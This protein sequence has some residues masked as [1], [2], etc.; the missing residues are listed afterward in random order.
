M[1]LPTSPFNAA[2]SIAAGKSVIQLKLT[3]SLTGVTGVATTDLLTKTAHGLTAGRQLLYVSGTGF[4]GLTAGNIYYVLYVDAN[5]FKLSATNGGAVFDFT[6]DG[7]AGVF[8]PV[9]VFEAMSLT[10]KIEQTLGDILVPDAAGVLRKARTWL[11]S[12]VEHFPFDTFEVKRLMDVFGGAMAGRAIGT[13]TL[14]IPDPDD[15][16][17]MIALKSEVDFACTVT[18]SGDG[19]YGN[20]DASKTSIDIESNKAGMVIWTLDSAP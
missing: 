9:H 17:G 18:R 16:S 10:S 11:K 20:S 2:K 1:S 4:T 3:P 14:W 13:A 19:S 12:Q 6:V 15:A 8:Q 7:S 5:T